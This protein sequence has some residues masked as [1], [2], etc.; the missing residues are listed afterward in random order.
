MDQAKGRK[1]VSAAWTEQGFRRQTEWAIVLPS[2]FGPH[3]RLVV[4]EFATG[5]T[6]VSLDGV[7][8]LQTEDGA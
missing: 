2:W 7:A 3:P 8:E 5:E 6:A 1:Y 4:H